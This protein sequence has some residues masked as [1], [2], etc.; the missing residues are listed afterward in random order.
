MRMSLKNRASMC[1]AISAQSKKRK[2][3]LEE[4]HQELSASRP[5]VGEHQPNSL[6]EPSYMQ[7]FKEIS[8]QYV[9]EHKSDSEAISSNGEFDDADHRIVTYNEDDTEVLKIQFAKDWQSKSKQKVDL[10][11]APRTV[12]NQALRQKNRGIPAE[13]AKGFKHFNQVGYMGRDFKKIPRWAA[14]KDALMKVIEH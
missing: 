2:E 13:R 8:S 1:E 11:Q 14:S 6:A 4:Q 3:E 9:L 7:E 5:L 12:F 10:D